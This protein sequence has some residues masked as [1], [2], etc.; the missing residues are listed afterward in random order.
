MKHS[1]SPQPDNNPEKSSGPE[2]NNLII[3]AR[4]QAGQQIPAFALPALDGSLWSSQQLHGKPALLVFFRFAACPFCNLRL[5][6]LI[7]LKEQLPADFQVV[8]VFDSSLEDLRAFS[9]RHDSAYP[10]LADAKGRVHRRFGVQYSWL[11]VIKGMLLRLP[12][13]MYSMLVKGYW[14]SAFSGA[15]NTMP[16]NF[17]LD[18]NGVIQRAYYGKDEGDHPPLQDV[19]A[20]A[21]Q[22]TEAPTVAD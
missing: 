22:Q 13:A 20:F 8:A 17:F 4:L 16:M 6:R 12:T 2:Q 7:Q 18:A 11:G 15:L 19:L 14:P 10:I 21:R 9:E 5:H 1:A 3:S